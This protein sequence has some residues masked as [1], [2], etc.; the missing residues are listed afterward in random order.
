MLL[1]IEQCFIW[2]LSKNIRGHQS[3][4][5]LMEQMD[6]TPTGW[7]ASWPANEFNT[8]NLATDLPMTNNNAT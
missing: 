7:M 2:H 3:G 6:P 1:P 4:S 5:C 8:I